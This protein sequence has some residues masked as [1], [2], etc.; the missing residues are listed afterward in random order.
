IAGNTKIGKLTHR[1]NKLVALS[2]LVML[3]ICAFGA[4][5]NALVEEEDGEEQWYLQDGLASCPKYTLEGP[6]CADWFSVS[7]EHDGSGARGDGGADGGEGEVGW[8]G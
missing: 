8:Q 4:T 7:D 1:T 2:V 3:L 6:D 5:V